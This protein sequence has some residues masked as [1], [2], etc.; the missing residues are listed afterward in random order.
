MIRYDIG[1]VWEKSEDVDL[2]IHYSDFTHGI[3]IAIG[4]DTFIGPIKFS[5]GR[6]DKGQQRFSF[7]AGHT[8]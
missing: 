3:G 4:A 5:Y 8:F 7:T 2:K 1:N 6:T